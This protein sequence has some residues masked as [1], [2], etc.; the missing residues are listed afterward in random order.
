LIRTDRHDRQAGHAHEGEVG[1]GAVGLDL[2][3]RHRPRE[4]PLGHDLDDRRAA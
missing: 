4:L 1:K 2:G 3:Q